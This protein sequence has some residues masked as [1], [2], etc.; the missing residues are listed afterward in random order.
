M[1]GRQVASWTEK[2]DIQITLICTS[3]TTAATRRDYVRR[4]P[5]VAPIRALT[6]REGRHLRWLAVVYIGRQDDRG[7]AVARSC[8]DSAVGRS[9][10]AE[11]GFTV[12][13]RGDM[14]RRSPV[15]S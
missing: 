10:A 9:G 8:A 14:W 6:F 2:T 4:F 15:A 1:S 5:R 7:A 12:V 13:A 11:P 3:R